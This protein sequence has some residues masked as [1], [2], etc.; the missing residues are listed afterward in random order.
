MDKKLIIEKII[1]RL[2]K[3]IT[4][5]EKS[6]KEIKKDAISSPSAMQSWSDTSR[7]QLGKLASNLKSSASRLKQCIKE[8]KKIEFSKKYKKIEVGAIVKTKKNKKICFYF[9]SPPN[10]GGETFKL[11]NLQIIILSIDSL[12]AQS[13]INKK[14]GDIIKLG[15]EQKSQ[16]ISILEVI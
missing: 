8:L 9:I 3:R 14:V 7:F 15:N 11:N 10:S 6:I 12:L 5:L 13:L 1:L 4:D 2:E 16:N